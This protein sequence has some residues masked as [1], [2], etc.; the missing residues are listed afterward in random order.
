[1]FPVGQ[2][3]VFRGLIDHH[4]L[5]TYGGGWSYTEWF[6]A[7]IGLPAGERALSPFRQIPGQFH[8]LTNPVEPQVVQPLGSFPAFYGTRRFITAFTSPP[9]VLILSQTNPVHATQSYL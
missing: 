5:K 9:P 4:A 1:L 6:G 8:Q 2:V 7:A 3:K